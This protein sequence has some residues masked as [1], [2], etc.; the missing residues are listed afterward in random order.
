MSWDQSF[1]MSAKIT[2]VGTKRVAR[3]VYFLRIAIKKSW[4]T[5]KMNCRQRLWGVSPCLRSLTMFSMKNREMRDVINW[6]ALKTNQGCAS[7]TCR[8]H[9]PRTTMEWCPRL[10]SRMR[11]SLVGVR[12]TRKAISP[13]TTVSCLC[14][15]PT[16][17]RE[18]R[19]RTGQTHSL[20]TECSSIHLLR[21]SEVAWLLRQMLLL[22]QMLWK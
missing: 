22:Q 7:R 5:T 17:E 4:K 16:S 15:G 18:H 9:L 14:T 21:V 3:L 11:A 12:R 10:L 19:S 2:W 8:S 20:A 13:S 1:R 6:R